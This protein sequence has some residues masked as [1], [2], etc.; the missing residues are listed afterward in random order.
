MGW[1]GECVPIEKGSALR[2]FSWQQLWKQSLPSFWI[3]AHAR[4]GGG[5][6][7]GPG[8]VQQWIR[9]QPL[10]Y[11]DIERRLNWSAERRFRA[12]A[13]AGSVGVRLMCWAGAR[14]VMFRRRLACEGCGSY[15][16]PSHTP[17]LVP[18]RQQSPAPQNPEAHMF[19]VLP[20]E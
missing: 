19:R 16:P 7:G 15:E 14:A 1:N 6:V 13:N 17:S 11:E 8:P 18:Y 9:S 10:Q 3:A 2:D 12:H 4:C 5:G 20:S